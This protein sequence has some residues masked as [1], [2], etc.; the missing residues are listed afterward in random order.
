M[1]WRDRVR[2][3][4]AT[5]LRSRRSVERDFDDELQFHLRESIDAYTARGLDPA[6]ARR[7]AMRDLGVAD[8]IRED[9]RE[10][11]GFHLID[12]LVQDVRY[13][14]RLVHRNPGFAV[15]AIVTVALGIGAT[16]A[17]FGVVDGVVLR[18]LPYPNP[19]R[20]VSLWSVSRREGIQRSTVAAA[21]YHDWRTESTSFVDLAMVRRIGNFNF[22][23]SGEPVRLQGARVTANLFDVLGVPAAIGRTFDT[24]EE[25]PGRDLVVVLSDALWTRSFGRDPSVVGRT[26]VMNTQSYL[27]VG[28]MPPSFAYPSR[29]FELWVPLV[30]DPEE[31]QARVPSNYVVVGRLKRGVGVAQAQA[32]M[33]AIAARL[34]A[35]YGRGTNGIEVVSMLGDLVRNVRMPLLVL[36]AG[37]GSLLVIGCATLANLLIARASS[38]SHELV[39]RAALGARR[40]RL[41]RQSITELVPLTL[42]GGVLG[43]VLAWWM[44]RAV[45]PWL[46]PTMPRME[47]IGIDVRVLMFSAGML[48]LIVVVIGCWPALQVA[49]WDIAAA[50]RESLRGA[51]T[52]LRGARLRDALVVAQ[53]A[54]AL[55]LAVSSMLLM[56]SFAGVARIDPGFRADGV[57]TLQFAIPRAKY[58]E[59]RQVSG[60]CREILVRV[61]RLPGVDAAGMVNR[62]P[63]VGSTQI[64]MIELERSAIPSNR[65]DNLDWRTATPDYFKAIGIPIVDGRSFSD[66]DHADAPRVGIIDERVA[67][68]AWPNESAIGK[69]FRI[70]FPDAPWITIVG[71]AGHIRHDALTLDERPQVYWNYLQ[72]GQDRM[73]LVVRTSLDPSGIARSLV[74][75]VR[76]VDPEQPVYDV[77]TMRTIVDR[78]LSD[79]WLTTTVFGGFAIVA[80]VMAAVGVYGVVSYAVGQ[81]AREFGI[82]IALGARKSELLML[83]VRQ[84][85]VLLAWGLTIGIAASLVATRLLVQLLYEISR[86]DWISFLAAA[87]LLA[88]VAIAASILPA[89]RAACVDP[90]TLLRS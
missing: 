17:V 64:G 31:I 55:L 25:R 19:D 53:I 50:L 90:M 72:R 21:R 32:E 87:I 76:A 66:A 83:V 6:A 22:T 84:G 68:L 52:A 47:S 78:S 34:D 70:P 11:R 49:R 75:E 10:A 62:L 69:R 9:L 85:G 28:V 4:F 58:P 38:R 71:V 35:R 80:L 15:A 82:R 67:R 86:T 46:P 45:L 16:T 14:L 27:V 36:F 26:I 89:R 54:A 5:F 48:A 12:A 37:A 51:S 59:D 18:P 7:A 79:R 20:L 63:L 88:I 23:A 40:G 8:A 74:A 61:Q 73:A 56:R 44:L 81:R 2:F 13:G 3:R 39:L 33:D 43:V 29:E 41:I 24:A 30:V 57:A 65:I 1:S 42:A 77:L 60:I